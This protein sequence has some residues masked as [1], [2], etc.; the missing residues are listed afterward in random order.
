MG[1]L[2]TSGSGI[3]ALARSGTAALLNA[4]SD[5]AGSG[6][7]YIIDEDA[8]IISV[9]EAGT[10]LAS[11]LNTLSLIDLNDDGRISTTEVK[12]AVKDALTLGG[13]FD[14][15]TG[16]NQV[17]LAFDSMNNMPSLEVEEF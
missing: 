15:S 7:N 13:L 5:E 11:V 12:G 16:I 3:N 17:A 10:D 4:A 14:G 2:N 9:V 6:I 1:A 8:L